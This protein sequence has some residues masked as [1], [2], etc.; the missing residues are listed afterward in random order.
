MRRAA[1]S[2]ASNIAEGAAKNIKKE[3]LKFL[4]IAQGS[5]SELDIQVVICKELD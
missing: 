5:L 3:F 2:V 1:V 4:Y